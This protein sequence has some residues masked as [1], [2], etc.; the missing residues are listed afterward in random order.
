[1]TPRPGF[2]EPPGGPGPFDRVRRTARR[3][4][5]RAAAHPRVALP[6]ARIPLGRRLPE[7]LAVLRIAAERFEDGESYRILG[8][9]WC[10]A[11]RPLNLGP[12]A[13][14]LA[15]PEVT[16]AKAR[17]GGEPPSELLRAIGGWSERHPELL[18]WLRGLHDG[19]H[20]VPALLVR[21][22]TGGDMPWELLWVTPPSRE[23]PALLGALMPVSR[24]IVRGPETLPVRRDP[25]PGRVVGYVHD[26][27]ADD[28]G[29]FEA[30][31][32]RLHR[33]MR[34]FLTDLEDAA[35]HTDLVYMACHGHHGDRLSGLRLGTLTWQELDRRPLAA[36]EK[37]RPVVFLNV[38]ETG[39][40]LDNRGQ[41]ERRLRGFAELFLRKGADGCIVAAG[42][43]GDREA[44]VLVH[45]LMADTARGPGRP[46]GGFLQ[47]FRAR[48][49]ERIDLDD[50]P[51][52][53]DED[54]DSDIEGQSRVRS[55]LY[56][57]MFHYYG[58]PDR[59]LALTAT[60]R[61]ATA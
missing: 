48:A 9:C 32:P 56:A 58:H 25:V 37:H 16:L 39:R 55:V 13:D 1:M 6:L 28:V 21:D 46:L 14:R 61:E 30:F 3:T 45:A 4:A 42:A 34:D 24:W 27:M 10:A 44:R 7:G 54:D 43:V 5:A 57:F 22:E 20:P 19:R 29:A 49:A 8:H 31:A 47:D 2:P 26:A 51:F 15:A 35:A 33:R 11:H 12:S 52:L 36:V 50:L 18:A 38:C 17:A 23:T 59:A 41:G 60:G 53:A 40:F